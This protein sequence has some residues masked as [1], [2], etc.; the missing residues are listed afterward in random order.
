MYTYRRKL[1]YN[2]KANLCEAL[3]I[4]IWKNVLNEYDVDTAYNNFMDL[5]TKQLNKTCPFSKTLRLKINL[6]KN[7]G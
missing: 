4:T 1:K 2:T 6:M 7:L 3:D 5:F